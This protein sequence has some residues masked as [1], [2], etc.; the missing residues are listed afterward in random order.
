MASKRSERTSPDEPI[1]LPRSDP[2]AAP[3][4][5]HWF[6]ALA[7]SSVLAAGVAGALA[8][9]ATLA[10]AVPFEPAVIALVVSGTL[11]VYNIDRLRDLERDRTLAPLRSAFIER[12]RKRLG[13]LTLLAAGSSVVCTLQLARTAWLLCGAVLALGLL[14]RRLKRIRGIKTLYLTSCW[15]AVVLGLP[16]LGA[17]P[18][19]SPGA[20]R[21]YWVSA[22]V[23]CAILSNLM[24]SNLDR[25]SGSSHSQ[26]GPAIAVAGL[27]IGFALVAPQALRGLAL[28]PAAELV[29]LSRFREG[30]R[31]GVVAVDGALF[32]GAG[33]A[34]I[35]QMLLRNAG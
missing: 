23:G 3:S 33:G 30:E 31:Q 27:G 16:L 24:A 20:E 15:L 35:V 34:I 28:I 13:L 6:D 26:L 19:S 12:N 5:R 18:G 10:F 14:H 25:R 17:G 4:I 32:A 1:A 8:W 9:A 11:V 2:S 21:V 29:A 22:V 7:Y